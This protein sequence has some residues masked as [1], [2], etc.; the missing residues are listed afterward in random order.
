M[1]VITEVT[2]LHY[3]ILLILGVISAGI[4]GVVIFKKIQDY[5]W[6]QYCGKHNLSMDLDK[7]ENALMSIQRHVD[8]YQK[9][10]VACKDS[11]IMS[12]SGIVDHQLGHIPRMRSNLK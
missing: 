6:H 9:G 2:I 4:I 5:K 10:D 3:L 12:I 1:E 8:H 11:E 7:M